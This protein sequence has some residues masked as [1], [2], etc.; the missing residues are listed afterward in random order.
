MNVALNRPA[1]MSSSAADPYSGGQYVASRAVDGNTDPIASKVDNSCV[2]TV[3]QDYAWWSVDLGTALSVA[4]VIFA[5]RA[6]A[7]G[8]VMLRLH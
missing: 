6:E 2:L 7:S 3:A 1:V 4:G 5:N 8:N